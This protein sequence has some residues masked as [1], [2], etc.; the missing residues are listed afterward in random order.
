MK[1][2]IDIVNKW[3]YENGFYLT[4]G[5]DRLS[6]FVAHLDLYRKV[7]GIPGDIAE[8]GVYKGASLSRWAIFRAMFSNEFAKKI[9][10]FDIF[11]AFPPTAF[12]DDIKKRAAFVDAG[13]ENSI[14]KSDL[15]FFLKARNL[16]NNVELIEG[17]ILETLPDFLANNPHTRF[18]LI[19]LDTDVYE[20]AKCILEHCWDRL[21]PG[22]ILI[23]D[24][25]A[26]F[27]GE[28][29]AVEKFLTSRNIASKVC[30]F[31]FAQTPCYVVKDSY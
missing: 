6:K 10:G 20:P 11:G 18:S 29:V 7:E 15:E 22:G 30:S 26:T 12:E 25:Y 13:G 24:D 31:P 4:A 3:E 8:F 19:N 17:D 28:T 2:N 14:S 5:A 1:E 9:F 16:N 27:A 23:L 21:T